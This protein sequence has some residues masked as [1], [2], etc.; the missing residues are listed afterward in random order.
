MEVYQTMKMTIKKAAELAKLDEY[1]T[2][3]YPAQGSWLDQFMP[4]ENKGTYLDSKLQQ[5]LKMLLGDLYEPLME[6]RQTVKNG[7]YVQAR[8]LDDV[9]VK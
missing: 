1:H 3:A 4:K 5:E 7:S 2:N 8:M 9:R 6:I